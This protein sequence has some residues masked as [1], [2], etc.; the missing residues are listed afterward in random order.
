[1][2][3]VTCEAEALV[4]LLGTKHTLRILRY[5]ELRDRSTRFKEL[6][7]DLKL[8]ATSL[9]NRL[10]ELVR[11][12]VVTRTT[13]PESPNKVEYSLSEKGILLTQILDSFS[14][15]DKLPQELVSNLY[16]NIVE[17]GIADE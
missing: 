6:E 9:A 17:A 10:Q 15:L 16:E 4:K 11:M 2:M 5:M 14:L 7:D 3:D 1:M 12:G 13:Y 8:N